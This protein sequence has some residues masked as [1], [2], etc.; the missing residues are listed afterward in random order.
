MMTPCPVRPSGPGPL[1]EV[2]RWMEKEIRA[3]QPIP[4]P[5]E[6]VSTGPRGVVRR[7]IGKGPSG[8]S[9]SVIIAQV[10]NEGADAIECSTDGGDTVFVVMK[11]EPLR[12]SRMLYW[13]GSYAMG[14]FYP[15][16]TQETDQTIWD[17]WGYVINIATG[18]GSPGVTIQERRVVWPSWVEIY[19]TSTTVN[20]PRPMTLVVNPARERNLVC[21]VVPGAGRVNQ[22]DLKEDVSGDT[23]VNYVDIT[24]GRHWMPIDEIRQEQSVTD[25]SD[26]TSIIGYVDNSPQNT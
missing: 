2:V 4:A 21:A 25:V 3:L 26:A 12:L 22:A 6:F 16:I 11:P 15:T 9:S 20:S 13:G 14:D 5:G 19:A 10:F 23:V 18:I 24:P 7:P 8:S 1:A 17:A